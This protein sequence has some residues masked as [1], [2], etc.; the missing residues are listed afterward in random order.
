M[1]S[2]REIAR[3]RDNRA[4]LLSA[5]FEHTRNM[6]ER[7]KRAK[8]KNVAQVL[9]HWRTDLQLIARRRGPIMGP[10]PSL[11][12]APFV[13]S[14]DNPSPSSPS[15]LCSSQSPLRVILSHAIPR[16][17]DRAAAIHVRYTYTRCWEV[18]RIPE[19]VSAPS[20]GTRVS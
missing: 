9:R 3:I 5:I 4:R 13:T 17:Y 7:Q 14:F 18:A 8:A 10:F 20:P 1:S 6:R 19:M 15:L 12:L 2:L 11:R 16:R